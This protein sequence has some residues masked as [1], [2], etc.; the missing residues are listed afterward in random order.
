MEP[1]TTL[2]QAQIFSKTLYY[3]NSQYFDRTRPDP[4]KMLVGALDFLQR[5]VPEILVDRF[6][7]R[8]PK[9][10]TVK[11]NGEQKIFSIE[12]VDSPWT[13]SSTMKEI[14]AFVEPRL[15]ARA[16]QR[17][18]AP[19]GGHR[20]DCHERDALHAR[21]A[22]GAAGCGQLQGHAHDDPGQVRRPRHR[23]RNGSQRPHHREEAHA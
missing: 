12:R 22:L 9:Q 1:A 11:V 8:D 13:L 2:S 21:P 16:D 14:F 17:S 4:K 23:D 5:D 10:V 20:N 6:P 18:G 3:V 7:E 15:R 19:S